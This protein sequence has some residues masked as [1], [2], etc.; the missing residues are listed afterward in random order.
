MAEVAK[1]VEIFEIKI[2][3]QKEKQSRDQHVSKSTP[4]KDVSKVLPVETR[5]KHVS[6]GKPF[7]KK[8]VSKEKLN[9][10]RKNK[11]GGLTYPGLSNSGKHFWEEYKSFYKN[12]VF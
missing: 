7:E 9:P 8:F 5:D 11:H 2:S 3:E 12:K 6:K 1:I 4:M 10:K